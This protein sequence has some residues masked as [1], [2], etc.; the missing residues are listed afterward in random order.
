MSLAL[1]TVRF[2]GVVVDNSFKQHLPVIA[3]IMAIGTGSACYALS[4]VRSNAASF[5]VQTF[6]WLIFLIPVA[7]MFVCSLLSMM[8]ARVANRKTYLGIVGICFALGIVSMLV[9]SSWLAD[10]SV[11]AALL[12]NSGE[13][14]RV[15]P[16]LDS[17]VTMIRDL[18][19]YFVVP[20]IGCIAGAWIGSRLHPMKAEPSGRK[21]KKR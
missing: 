21:K 20:T 19:A 2:K 13:N 5:D 16:I 12:A 17:P 11:A 6:S 10:P 3:A 14:A 18:L 1:C 4:Y 15:V 7:A 8:T 9:T